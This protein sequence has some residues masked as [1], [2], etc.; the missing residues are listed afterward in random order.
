MSK[1]PTKDGWITAKLQA[2]PGKTITRDMA[3]RFATA[4]EPDKYEI[5]EFRQLGYG[6]RIIFRSKP[7]EA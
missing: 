3:V 2:K 4:G 5:G 6:A 7:T 1:F